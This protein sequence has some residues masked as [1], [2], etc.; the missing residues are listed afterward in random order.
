MDIYWITVLLILYLEYEL[1]IARLFIILPVVF[2]QIILFQFE[3]Y[4]NYTPKEKMRG[5]DA[6]GR[7]AARTAQIIC[8]NK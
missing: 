3:I 5:R 8:K 2:F 1:E 6:Y 4:Q 7:I